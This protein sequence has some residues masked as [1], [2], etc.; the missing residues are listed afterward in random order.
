M[1]P[2]VDVGVPWVGVA[3]VGDGLIEADR[4]A[5][6]VFDHGLT[7]GDGVFETLRV[8]GAT[9]FAMRR[10]LERLASSAE[11]LG[12]DA[13]APTLVAEAVAATVSANA[14]AGVGGDARLRITLTAGPA[15]PGSGRSPG[16]RPTL[17]VTMAPLEPWLPT[18]GVAVVP[19]PRNERGALAGAKTVSYAE[20]VVA[21]GW[22]RQRGADEGIFANLAGNL[23]EGTGS[24]VFLVQDG[25]LVTPPLSSGCLAGVTR[26]LVVEEASFEVGVEALDLVVE[27]VEVAVPG[28]DLAVA[29]TEADVAVGALREAQ[30]AFLT[31]ST[32]EIQPIASVDGFSLPSAPG[33][34]TEAVSRWFSRLA[35][36]RPEP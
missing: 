8:R 26:A 28:I 3:W 22:A 19:W 24:N 23:C 34:V 18:T 2:S 12:L 6:S 5:V 36:T 20:N 15:P 33:P 29:V 17:I 1:N 32:R 13:P 21:L 11:L 9:P 4:A 30:E 14:D 31:S 16:A 35:S 10:H 25:R 7:T 27:P